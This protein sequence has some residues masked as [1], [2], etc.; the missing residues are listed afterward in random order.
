MLIFVL[1]Y[2]LCC[3]AFFSLVQKP[4]FGWANRRCAATA[5]SFSDVMAVYRH[6]VAT[7]AIVASYL[8]AIPLVVAFVRTLVPALDPTW[9]LGVYNALIA[10]ALGFLTVGDTALYGFWQSKIDASVFAYLRNPRGAFASVSGRYVAGGALAAIL[11]GAIFFSAAQWIVSLYAGHHASGLAWWGYP[12]AVFEF[13]LCVGVLFAIIRGLGIRPHSPSIA[14]FSKD[15]F[16]NHW[17][18]NPGYNIIYTLTLKD[19]YAGQFQWYANERCD[20]LVDS[21]FPTSGKPARELLKTKRPN[22]L[23]VI[24]ESFGAEFT[25]CL[26]GN[27]HDVTPQFD[28]LAHEGVLFTHCLAGS[29][30][31]DRGLTCLLSGLPGQPLASVMR[32]SSKLPKLPGL[33]RR[34]AEEGYRTEAVQG[35]DLTVM[36][37]NDYFLA[38]GH[39]TLKGEGDMPDGSARGKWGVHDGDVMDAV[40]RDIEKLTA[41]GERWFKTLLTISSHEPFDVPY[42]RLDDP[43][44]N[45][46]AYTDH[47]LGAMVEKLRPTK[48]W[49]D[50]LMVVVADHGFNRFMQAPDRGKFAHIPVL[51]LGGAVRQPAE[52]D[53][54][55]S[56]TDIAATLLGQMDMPHDEF[57]FSR[58]VLADTYVHPFSLHVFSN[59]FFLTDER[60]D[61]EFD[62]VSDQAVKGAD[63]RREEIGKA[64]TQKVHSYLGAM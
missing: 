15:A 27:G 10:L 36:H 53:T 19:E 64:V 18:L 58:D 49:D 29:Y 38:C 63:E 28:R 47:C 48:A 7:D 55:M 17:A 46:F 5:I 33:P 31:T 59:G 44:E 52:I 50:L 60:G 3:V 51:L 22:I 30:R 2:W 11:V 54:L 39:E 20:E 23:L 56:Q 57:I 34:L 4:L 9:I 35:G 26:G 41:K 8:S 61:T 42:S 13:L 45:A 6:G 32:Y 1:C 16:L 12:V 62:N 24:W 25:K 21:L 43:V 37:K 40:V 14:F